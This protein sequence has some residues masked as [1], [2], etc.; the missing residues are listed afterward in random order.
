MKGLIWHCKQVQWH[1][2]LLSEDCHKAEMRGW[3][4]NCLLVF[5]CFEVN[6][7]QKQISEAARRI[8]QLN[9]KRFQETT[10]IVF[11]FAHLSSDVMPTEQAGQFI[12]QLAQRLMPD[13]ATVKI[14]PFN[15]DKEVGIRLLGKNE[16]VSYFA[17]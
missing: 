6:D 14:L 4:H 15:Q 17:Y 13:F 8:R 10:V 9:R 5:C 12:E 11:P 3:V 7:D 2:P 16:D 1:P